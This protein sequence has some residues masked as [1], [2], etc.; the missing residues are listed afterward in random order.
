[1]S[2]PSLPTET[3]NA[4]PLAVASTRVMATQSMP[5]GLAAETISVPR[6]AAKA[7]LFLVSIDEKVATSI[8][9]R[10]SIDE[11]RAI[12]EATD[13]LE[14]V[15]PRVILAIHR[16]F[17]GAIQAGVPTSLR[18]SGAYLRR[19]AGKALGEHRA[20]DIWDGGTREVSPTLTGLA[21][22]DPERLLPM[23]EREHPQTLAV[24]LALLD[25]KKGAAVLSR[26]P[27]DVQIDVVRR[28]AGLKAVPVSVVRDIE[29]QLSQEVAALGE[30]ERRDIDGLAVATDLLKQLGE[31][32]A[33]SILEELADADA[34]LAQ[35]VRKALFT[36]E[37]L[38]RLEGRAVQ[39]MLKEIATEQLVLA[40][41]TASPELQEKILANVSSRAAANLREELELM[42]PVRVRDVE[43]AQRAIVDTALR[44]E[45]DGVITIAR[46][47][48]GDLV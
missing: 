19:L 18:G 38:R 37:D 46:E 10:M 43:E 42:G 39:A 45:R 33:E 11:V 8:L 35:E 16:D 34:E 31:Q 22:L 14:E 20:A 21:E 1:M 5:T 4:A 26:L 27:V 47:G 23:L 13:A 29:T 28:A 40:L 25:A 32:R 12:R 36:F 2:L 44:L 9:G 24:V 30:V 3:Q 6:G 17:I 41:K 48:S 7:L 15:D